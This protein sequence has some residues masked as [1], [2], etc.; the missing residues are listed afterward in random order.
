MNEERERQILTEAMKH[1]C[2][3]GHVYYDGRCG[4]GPI[5]IHADNCP[6]GKLEKLRY[7]YWGMDRR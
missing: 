5:Y 2:C 7:D 1:N 3:N 6:E 4:D